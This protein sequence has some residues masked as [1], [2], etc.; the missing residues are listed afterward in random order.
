LAAE[1]AVI[2]QFDV[3]V[4]VTTPVLAL[5]EQPDEAVE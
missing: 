4:K 2:T 3:V 5:T 1:R